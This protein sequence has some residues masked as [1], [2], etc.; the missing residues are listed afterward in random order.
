VLP[1]GD[2]LLAAA[3]GSRGTRL[4]LGARPGVV[5][6]GRALHLSTPRG[7][8]TL[9]L[10][11]FRVPGAHNL[12]NAAAAALLALRAGATVDALQAAL[13]QLV[14]LAHRMQLVHEAAD[15]W[16]IDDSKATNLDAARVGVSGIERPCVVLLGGQGKPFADG[17]LGAGQLAPAL[18]RH[19]A[20]VTF[21][22]DGPR[23]AD[24]LGAAGV[25]AH[26][27]AGLADA[28]AAARGL[29]RP[30]DAVL[31]SPMCASFDEFRDYEH[32]GDVFRALA[33][34]GSP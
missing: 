9:S 33:T 27:A 31:L 29:A 12:D 20:V 17:S 11:G 25:T 26:R 34:G 30:G 21:G 15:V 13:P 7:E 10:D 18:A 24:E 22:Q 19:R 3:A 8:A 32:R 4:W 1:A 23:I 28:V 5:R 6:E 14:A 16:W 2:E